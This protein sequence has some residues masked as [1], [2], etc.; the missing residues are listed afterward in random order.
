MTRFCAR[1]CKDESS[2]FPCSAVQTTHAIHLAL[3][4]AFLVL[5]MQ[6]AEQ[7]IGLSSSKVL[8]SLLLLRRLLLHCSSVDFECV[9]FF[10][11]PKMFRDLLTELRTNFKSGIT[12]S[13]LLDCLA[14]VI[15]IDI[16]EHAE[17]TNGESFKSKDWCRWFATM[18]QNGLPQ[19]AATLESLRLK[20]TSLKFQAYIQPRKQFSEI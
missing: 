3:R 1:R 8:L 15:F 20:Q 5:G 6:V 7:T 14:R 9:S 12:R 2:L 19:F 16:L 11:K 13:I 17:I 10:W 4:L 18:K